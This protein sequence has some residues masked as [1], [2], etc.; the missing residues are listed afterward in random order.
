[1][2]RWRAGYLLS[3]TI[4]NLKIYNVVG[5]RHF[6]KLAE[7][8]EG[9]ATNNFKQSLIP[10]QIKPRKKGNNRGMS[11]DTFSENSPTP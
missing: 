10:A 3:N 2:Y 11:N 8:S 7:T 1:M 6:A 5:V 4:M 9:S